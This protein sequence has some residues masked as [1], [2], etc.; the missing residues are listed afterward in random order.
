M[1]NTR[2]GFTLSP[3]D[4]RELLEMASSKRLREDF[5]IIRNRHNPFLVNGVVDL[6]R[7]VSFLNEYNESINHYTRPLRRISGKDMR[8]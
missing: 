8:L 7:F 6:E 3:E 4:K 1:K 2:R 5:R